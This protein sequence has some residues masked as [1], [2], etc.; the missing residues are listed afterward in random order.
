MK[1][2]EKYLESCSKE[3]LSEFIA[4]CE[5]KLHHDAD[6]EVRRMAGKALELAHE[7]QA[8]RDLLRR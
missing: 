8:V 4:R 3:E 6:P 7:E 2:I 5:R 1:K